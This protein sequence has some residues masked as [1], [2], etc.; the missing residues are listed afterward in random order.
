MKSQQN[1]VR[2]QG[3]T[4]KRKWLTWTSV[5]VAGLGLA[6]VFDPTYILKGL[7]SSEHFFRG[8][9]TSYWRQVLTKRDQTAFSDAFGLVLGSTPD[10]AG[11]PV[12]ID[13]L[14]DKDDQIVHA[15]CNSLALNGPRASAALPLLATMLRH[16]NKYHRRSASNA[17]A[18][19]VTEAEAD[20][21][22]LGALIEGLKEEDGFIVYH[23]AMALGRI[24]PEA[25]DAAPLLSGLLADKRDHI[26]RGVANRIKAERETKPGKILMQAPDGRS[27]EVSVPTSWDWTVGDAAVWALKRIHQEAPEKLW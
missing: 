5:G 1:G 3:P 16:S 26:G 2:W 21:A 23:C 6:I 12:L 7:L 18:S 9:P 11:V 15:S 4:M 14:K 20:P 22:L 24:G 25:K 13:L 27:L 10:A 8:R 17:L 19:I